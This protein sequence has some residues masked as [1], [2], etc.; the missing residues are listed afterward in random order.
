[1]RWCTRAGSIL[2]GLTRAS[3]F[4]AMFVQVISHL[5]SPLFVSLDYS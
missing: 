3:R 5:L 4:N 1:M 2:G